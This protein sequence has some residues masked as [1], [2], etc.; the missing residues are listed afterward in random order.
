[1]CVY[2]C[3]YQKG[4]YRIKVKL[5]GLCHGNPVHFVLF[6]QLL[7]LKVRDSRQTNMSSEHYF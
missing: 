3:P 5:K 1:M 4:S 7:A 6:C 2:R